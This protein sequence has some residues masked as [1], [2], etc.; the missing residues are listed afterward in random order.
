MRRSVLALLAIVTIQPAYAAAVKSQY[1]APNGVV[2]DVDTDE[3]AGRKEYASPFV[4]F[5]SDG[6]GGHGK[7]IV[8]EVFDDG[9]LRG[10][11]V[12]GFIFYSGD[13]R[14]Y[15]TA[16]FRGGETTNYRR[17]GSKVVDCH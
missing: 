13:W 4:E 11:T 1:T 5:Q 8:G 7:A 17:T 15:S 10:L 16:I 6:E 2:V 9:K 3:F 14:F 12:Q